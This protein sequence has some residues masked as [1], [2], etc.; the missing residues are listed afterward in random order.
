M[1][2]ILFGLCLLMALEGALRLLNIGVDTSLVIPTSTAMK[3]DA[4]SY[5]HQF[6]GAADL[7]YYG[8]TD[9][10]GPEI[11][12]FNLPKPENTLRIIVLGESTVMGIGRRPGPG[13]PKYD[14][15]SFDLRTKRST[16]RPLAVPADG[17][18]VLVYGSATRDDA[19]HFYL[20][21]RAVVGNLGKALA[22][23][24]VP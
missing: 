24:V 10:S 16:A 22:W 2:A 9:L 13:E 12:P 21:G 11:R 8:P 14:W 19:G 15:I 1:M 5:S 3:S 20:G 23:K 4:P 7:V 18:D 17:R 6:N